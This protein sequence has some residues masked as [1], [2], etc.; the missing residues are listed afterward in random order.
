MRSNSGPLAGA[1]RRALGFPLALSLTFATVPSS[2][3]AH[4]KGSPGAVYTQTNSPG[5]NEVLVYDRAADGALA[6]AGAVPTGGT[7]T[8]TGLGN[9]GAV[10]LSGDGRRLFVVNAGSDEI[11]SFRVT[12]DGLALTAVGPGTLPLAIN[13]DVGGFNPGTPMAV[14]YWP[15]TAVGDP[16]VEGYSMTGIDLLFQWNFKRR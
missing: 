10:V 14:G 6:F 2:P 8:G 16:R 12:P 3:L 5:G 11:S 13:P 1:R 9:Q 4:A 7:G 15:F